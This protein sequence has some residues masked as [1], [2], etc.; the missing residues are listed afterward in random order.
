MILVS[1]LFG[2]TSMLG[3]GFSNA[4]SKPLAQEFGPS[5]FIFYRELIL[6]VVLGVAALPSYS[7]AVDHWDVAALAVGLGVAGY[8]PFLAFIHGIRRSPLGVVAPIAAAS[9]L[10]TVLLSFAFLKVAIGQVEWLAIALVVLA[11]VLVS[12]EFTD[13][14]RSKLFQLSSGVPLAM[15]AVVGWGFFFFFLIALTR[16]LGPWVTA[17]LSELGVTLAVGIHL[18]LTAQKVS[19]RDLVRFSVISNGLLSCIAILSFTIGVSHF[20]I[21]IVAALSHSTAL[22]SSGLG[23]VLYQERMQIKEKLG[24]GIMVIGVAIISF[25]NH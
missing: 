9:P 17:F 11:N 25:L 14:R 2:L 19:W 6:S 24:A 1:V 10:I 7:Q 23:A 20:N 16:A 15:V 5:R 4:Y 8:V 13:L 22:I 12:F 18:L 3:F 21:G